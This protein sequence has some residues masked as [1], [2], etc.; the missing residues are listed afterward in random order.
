MSI[1]GAWLGGPSRTVPKL[2][3]HRWSRTWLTI[4]RG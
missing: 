4:L 1:Y 2:L 3:L